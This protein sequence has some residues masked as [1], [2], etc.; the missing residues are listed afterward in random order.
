MDESAL[1]ELIASLGVQLSALGWWMDFWTALV[2]IGCA[3]ELY[4]VIHAYREDRRVWFQARTR[5]AIAFPEKPSL[6]VLFF[7]VL[8]VAAVVI[9]N[10]RRTS[11]RLEIRRFADAAS[12]GEQ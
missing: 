4:F 8:S 3:G 10:C 6:W 7:E 5:G 11:C 2:I 12:H 1:K 9:G